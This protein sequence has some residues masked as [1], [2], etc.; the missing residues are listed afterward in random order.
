MGGQWSCSAESCN[1]VTS[2]FLGILAWWVFWWSTVGI[3]QLILCVNLWAAK[4]AECSGC[5]VLFLRAWLLP[6]PLCSTL[7]SCRRCSDIHD[8]EPG[9]HLWILDAPSCGLNSYEAPPWAA[10]GKSGSGRASPFPPFYLIPCCRAGRKVQLNSFPVL[11]VFL[12]IRHV[13]QGMKYLFLGRTVSLWL[14]SEAVLLLGQ[15]TC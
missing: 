3:Q 15:W 4:V 8:R 10:E 7:C 13:G 2:W 5:A 6:V 12:I 14:L 9:K 11:Y 1:L